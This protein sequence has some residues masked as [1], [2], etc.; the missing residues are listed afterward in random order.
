MGWWSRNCIV[1]NKYTFFLNTYTGVGN[2]IGT[3][4]CVYFIVLGSSRNGWS[5]V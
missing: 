3:T 4:A 5:C 2:I 1:P